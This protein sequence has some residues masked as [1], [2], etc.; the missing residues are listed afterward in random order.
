MRPRRSG[1]I[2]KCAGPISGTRRLLKVENLATAYGASQVLFDF[3]FEIRDGEVVT[4]LG[5][6]GMGKTTTVRSI[7]GL[8]RSFKGSISF[9][10][11]RI[12]SMSTDR[13]ARLG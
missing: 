12:E 5:R 8:T 3:S 2:R 6:N 1:P 9:R 4:L 10:G 13:I 7:M 11:A